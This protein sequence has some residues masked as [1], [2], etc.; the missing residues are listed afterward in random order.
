MA[1]SKEWFEHHLT[2]KG[3]VTGSEKIDFGGTKLK[4]PP[5]DKVL[6]V[7][8]H[9]RMAS[10]FSKIEEWHTVEWRHDDEQKIKKLTKK[11]GELPK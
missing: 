10:A 3:W 1:L 5:K 11:F 2:P 8:L 6:T 7:R 4:E 9:E